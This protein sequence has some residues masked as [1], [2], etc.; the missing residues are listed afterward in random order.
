MVEFNESSKRLWTLCLK[1]Y[2]QSYPMAA[3]MRAASSSPSNSFD[4]L[5]VAM[6][7]EWPNNLG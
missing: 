5:G 3:G 2:A 1:R 4:A 6:R 7:S